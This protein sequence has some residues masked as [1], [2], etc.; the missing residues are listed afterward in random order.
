MTGTVPSGASTL[1]ASSE[2]SCHREHKRNNHHL[3]V[4]PKRNI[5]TPPHRLDSHL[6]E[7]DGRSERVSRQ[8][9]VVPHTDLSKVTRM[10]LLEGRRTRKISPPLSAIHIPRRPLNSPCRSWSCGGAD[11]RP[12][13]DL[14]DAF[15]AF[16]HDR[17]RP[18]RV[19]GA[20]GCWRIGWAFYGAQGGG[21]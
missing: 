16:R 10:V 21:G 20:F 14:P 17:D 19:L 4:S 15:C 12:N 18:R 3:S 11:L 5:L 7:V 8:L 9:V 1:A 6:V 13:H 2:M